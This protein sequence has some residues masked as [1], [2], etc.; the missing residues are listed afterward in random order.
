MKFSLA[1]TFVALCAGADITLDEG[2][3]TDFTADFTVSAKDVPFGYRAVVLAQAEMNG[4]LQLN[5]FDEKLKFTYT[6]KE[7]WDKN[8]NAYLGSIPPAERMLMTGL[9]GASGEIVIDGPA[10]QA[11][12]REKGKVT[13]GPAGFDGE[14][15]VHLKVPKGLLPPG[16]VLKSD[17]GRN[18]AMV[19]ERLNYMPHTVENG[20][21]I[22]REPVSPYV[23]KYH[24]QHEEASFTLQTDGTPVSFHSKSVCDDV[25]MERGNVRVLPEVSVS[26]KDWTAGAGDVTPV[27]CV[28]S[29][30]ADL[31]EH[32]EV[33]RA[34]A[35][36]DVLMGQFAG[37]SGLK[38]PSLTPLLEQ[39]MF[40]VDNVKKEPAQQQS[41]T[42]ALFAGVAGMAGGAVVFALDKAFKRR[43][44]LLLSEA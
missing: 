11:T 35:V 40:L 41:W 12:I 18:L 26:V 14:Y 15:C 34:A 10:G 22:F 36:F 28:D 32:P 21:V 24:Y 4:R 13:A 23:K 39:Q 3:L 30:V 20:D 9:S 37:S 19:Q 31:S 17:V 2:K 43:E 16:S 29:S 33:M 38:V 8:A 25:C 5:L 44:P 7:S 1:T 27:A 42:V 6:G